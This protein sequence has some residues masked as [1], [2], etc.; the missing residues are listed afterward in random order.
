[1]W[2]QDDVSTFKTN[3][4]GSISTQRIQRYGSAGAIPSIGLQDDR[5]ACLPNLSSQDYFP[6]GY[7]KNLVY[8]TSM[9]TDEDFR[10]RFTA[11][12]AQIRERPGIFESSQRCMCSN[13]E[14]CIL[15]S[16][17]NNY[18]RYART[19]NALFS[20]FVTVLRRQI[21]TVYQ[22]KSNSSLC[23]CVLLKLYC[24][25]LPLYTLTG[26]LFFSLQHFHID[27]FTGRT[28]R[29]VLVERSGLWGRKV[30]GLKSDSTE[31]PSCIRPV[32]G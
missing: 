26:V 1:M 12:T 15:A 23:F 9:T 22:C 30:P 19:I 7:K 25:Q 24:I 3:K 5:V 18:L 4:C 13:C 14:A 6:R 16:L 10:T 27:P 17:L 29:T 11:A 2:F 32:A 20:L 21:L 31:D 28:G 8:E